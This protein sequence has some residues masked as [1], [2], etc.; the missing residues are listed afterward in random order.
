MLALDIIFIRCSVN[1]FL[2]IR[3]LIVEYRCTHDLILIKYI[4]E[5]S[6]LPVNQTHQKIYL[7]HFKS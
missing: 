6:P 4:L 1:K 7:K 5:K 2:L 3:M